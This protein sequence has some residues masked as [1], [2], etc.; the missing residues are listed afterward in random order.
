MRIVT[1]NVFPPA[2]DVVS[3][4]AAESGHELALVVTTPGPSS[5]RNTSY[6]RVIT[7]VP[8]GTDV[9]VT[10]RLRT[11]ALPLIQALEPDLIVSFTFPYRIPPEVIA[12]ARYGAVNM[13]PTALPAYRGPNPLRGI[14]DGYP[15]LGA[16]LHWTAEEYDTGRILSQHTAP[17]PEVVTSESILD[18]WLPLIGGALAEGIDRAV[19]GET[20]TLQDDDQSSYGAKFTDEEYW[21]TPHETRQA[22]QY[23]CTALN[24]FGPAAKMQLGGRDILMDR[25]DQLDNSTT[26]APGTITEDTNE[27]F[28]LQVLDGRVRVMTA[29]F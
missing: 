16:T 10:T 12:L 5:R 20:G 23:K 28:V 25:V 19:T 2:Y 29:Q 15:L 27:S 3:S 22:L 18:S 21:L 24:F 11:V 4:W 9:L 6:Q 8:P 7:S 13:H 14:Y 1:F 17:L 26:D